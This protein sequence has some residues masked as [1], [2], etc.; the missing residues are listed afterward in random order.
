[1]KGGK[2]TLDLSD[3]GEVS[4]FAE[5]KDA[6]V[7]RNGKVVYDMDGDG[8]NVIVLLDTTLDDLSA[9]DFIF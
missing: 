9:S 6:S 7:E 3:L 4:T 8:S 1:M 2:D 5:F